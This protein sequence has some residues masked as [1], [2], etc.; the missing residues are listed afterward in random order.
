MPASPPEGGPPASTPGLRIA[1]WNVEWFNALFDD[2]GRMLDDAEPSQ[3]HGV[4]RGEQLGAIGIVMTALQADALVVVEAPDQSARRSC[5]RALEGFAAACGL[6]TRRAISGHP[7][8]SE[9]EIAV[10]YDP[11][12][13]ALHHDPQDGPPGGH[14]PRFDGVFH[15]DLDADDLPE[16]VRW[17]RPPLE[18]AATGGGR[19]FRLIGVHAKSKAPYGARDADHATRIAIENRRKQ[20]AQC[21]WLR[22]RVEAHLA[23]GDSVIVA[24]DFNDGPGLD[25]YERL[26]GRSGVEVVLGPGAEPALRVHDPHAAMTL[27]RRIGLAPTTARFFQKQHR[28]YFEALLDFVMVSP[29]LAAL[30]PDWRIWHPFNDPRIAAVPDLREA[31]LAASDH[32]PVSVDLPPVRDV[33]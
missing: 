30:R 33:I 24:G 22:R 1:T 23:A 4:T 10:M 28:R 31:L 17:S 19:R 14:A 5:V 13:I 15:L 8:D 27:G 25:D 6:R 9:Q 21:V 32:F 29:D 3:R 11:D 7:S 12:R 20:L 26:F 2:A 16:M 18:L